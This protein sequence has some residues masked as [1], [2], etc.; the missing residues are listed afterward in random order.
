M[1]GK[2]N[3]AQLVVAIQRERTLMPILRKLLLRES[4]SS[5]PV[6][7]LVLATLN[8]SLERVLFIHR[9]QPA[10]HGSLPWVQLVSK[11][12]RWDRLRWPPTSLEVAVGSPPCSTHSRTRYLL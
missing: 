6:A 4:Q 2:A 10:A 7:I 9:G 11:A 8:L 1:A 12:K 5:L 3:S